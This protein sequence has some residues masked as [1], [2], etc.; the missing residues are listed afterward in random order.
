[1]QAK[2]KNNDNGKVI[3]YNKHSNVHYIPCHSISS[4]HTGPLGAE[5]KEAE[6]D[7]GETTRTKAKSDLKKKKDKYKKLT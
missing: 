6:Q 5:T 7:C 4:K 2:T 3:Y 1:M